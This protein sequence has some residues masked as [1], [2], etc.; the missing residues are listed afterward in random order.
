ML[1]I[2]MSDEF[3]HWLSKLSDRRGQARIVARIR[4]AGLGNFG[5]VASVG[6]GVS[7]MRVHDGPGYRIYFA[8]R[9]KTVFLMLVGGDK[10]GRKR[11]IE[12]AK[13]MLAR[14]DGKNE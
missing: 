9:G 12:R 5:D 1:T 7:E 8:R 14:L 2:L 4:S 11:D 6:G 13:E 10:S 3:D